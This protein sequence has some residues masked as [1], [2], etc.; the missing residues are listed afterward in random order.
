MIKHGINHRFGN[1]KTGDRG[2]KTAFSTRN[3]P[4]SAGMNSHLLRRERARLCRAK[5]DQYELGLTHPPH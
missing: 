4:S 1:A 3:P 2:G 5:G